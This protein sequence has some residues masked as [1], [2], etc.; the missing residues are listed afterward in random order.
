MVST[1]SL[2]I[3]LLPKMFS[4][5]QQFSAFLEGFCIL[6]KEEPDVVKWHATGSICCH[7]VQTM[8]VVFANCVLLMMKPGCVMHKPLQEPDDQGSL[9][10]CQQ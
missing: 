9:H 5:M 2:L 10:N 1:S 6:F 8:H 3:K 7:D 4:W